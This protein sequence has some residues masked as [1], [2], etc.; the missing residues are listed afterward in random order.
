MSEPFFSI[1][2]PTFNRAHL[3]G[4]TIKSVQNQGF[5]SWELIVVDDGS[6][7]A[8]KELI[9]RLIVDDPRITYLYQQNAER[10]TARNLGITQSKGEYVCFI[11]S[12]DLYLDNNLTDWHQFISTQTILPAF[13]YANIRY[14]TWEEEKVVT[15]YR[16]GQH[17]LNFLLTNPIVPSRVCI[18]RSILEVHRFDPEVC[19]CEDLTLWLKLA[20]EYPVLEATHVASIYVVHDENS[21]AAGSRAPLIMLKGLTFFFNKYPAIRAKINT[22]VFK[23]YLSE[24]H[25][26]VAKYYIHHGR[27]SKAFF[28][29]VISLLIAPKHKHTKYRLVTIKNLLF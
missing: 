17:L 12:D 24:V 11:D 15:T 21:T 5:E 28:H 14:R 7:D 25:T 6:T 26:N 10:S 13:M 29:L 2:V 16:N 4:K 1:I 8:T 22:S 19:I 9:E 18:S 3:I 27:K 23:F 20:N